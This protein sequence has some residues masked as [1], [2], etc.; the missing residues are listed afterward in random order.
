MS[1]ERV[2]TGEVMR[3]IS[4][5]RTVSRIVMS[6]TTVQAH[7]ALAAVVVAILIGVSGPSSSRVLA[8]SPGRQEQSSE[9]KTLTDDQIKAL[10]NQV[11]ELCGR[12]EYEQALSVLLEI[13]TARPGDSMALY[14]AACV[15]AQL[16]QLDKSVSLLHEAV[17]AG[18]VSF[19]TMKVD[20][21][22]EPIREHPEYEALL[23]AINTAYEN[24]AEF[25]LEW[26]RK[27]LG[28]EAIIEKE[29]DL[30]LVLATSLSPETAERMKRSVR[31]QMEYQ[32]A[33]LFGTAP[34]AYVLLLVPTPEQADRIINSVRVGGFYDHDTRRLVT[35][36]LGPSLRHEITHVLHHAQMDRLG[37]RHPM[38]IQEG[39]ALA[40]EHY[41]AG[42]GGAIR[43]LANARN[44]VAINLSRAAALTDWRKFVTIEASQFNQVR[45]RARY[46]EARA[47]FQ[48]VSE[49]AP[50]GLEAWYRT[51]IETYDEDATGLRAFETVYGQPLD[52]IERGYRVWLRDTEKVPESVHE[53]EPAVGAWVANQMAND[54]VGI[55][56]VHPGGA[57]REAGLKP[58]DII[59]EIDGKPV[60][61]AEEL[62]MEVL[63]HREGEVIR[64]KIRRFKAEQEVTITLRP[65]DTRRGVEHLQEPG[66]AI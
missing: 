8:S 60:Y 34:S 6:S 49:T 52:Q 57:G 42:P 27:S 14:N 61:D 18:F 55:V 11:A 53:R 38:W 47:M 21:D 9:P 12:K 65:V 7:T 4:K 66:V 36:D 62:V 37:Q 31:G 33:H 19:D 23:K 35:R 56:A 59:L 63:R 54:G 15:Q 2:R 22:L 20:P 24:A 5:A 40:F 17:L 45:A 25:M 13:L 1:D 44:N 41:E 16:G 26:S 28:D 29:D 39:L 10:H 64:L 32:I 30:R 3:Q 51:Y 58:R 43:V 48:Y 46:A 50:G